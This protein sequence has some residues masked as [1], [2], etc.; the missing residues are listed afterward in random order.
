MHSKNS[1]WIGGKHSVTAAV[2]KKKRK[3]LQIV[4]L[5]KNKF[6]D[7]LKIKY[8]IENNNFFNK[9]FIQTHIAH[10]GVAAQV[11]LLPNIPLE[12]IEKDS[13]VIMLDGITDP[14]NI[15]SIVRTSVAFGIKSMIVRDKEFNEKSQALIKTCSGTIEDIDICKVSNLNQAIK[16][17]KKNGFWVVGLDGEAQDNIDDHKW[18]KKNLIIFG[19]EGDGMGQL[20]KN[21]CDYRVKIQINKKVESL[22][23]S[24]AAAIALHSLS[25]S[26][27]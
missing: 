26:L 22:N 24:T 14:G 25:R 13:T 17:L 12:K 11:S 1:I 8:K 10:Q 16:Q 3:I 21:N 15:G 27:T 4:A 6:F 9:I 18:D 7:E 20:I 19:S 2:L 23:V 5:Q